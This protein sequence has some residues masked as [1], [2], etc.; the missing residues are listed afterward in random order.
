ME[1]EIDCTV[2]KG[3]GRIVKKSG[4]KVNEY[5]CYNCGG[6]GK[7]LSE[8]GIKLRN[9]IMTHCEINEIKMK[10]D[11]ISDRMNYPKSMYE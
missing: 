7:T 2:C 6:S 4:K 9:F 8:D 1:L 10:L 3:I 5:H 11:D